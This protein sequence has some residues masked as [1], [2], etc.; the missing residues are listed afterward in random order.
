MRRAAGFEA[1]RR[2]NTKQEEQAPENTPGPRREQGDV[3]RFRVVC[4]KHSRRRVEFQRYRM[5][6]EAMAV[7]RR[8]SELG[9]EAC[10]E[11]VAR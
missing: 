11:E 7:A 4:I 6:D 9:C 5:R 10:V 1:A 2:V 3:L 8:L